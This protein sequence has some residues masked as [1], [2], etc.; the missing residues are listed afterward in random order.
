MV[1]AA[2]TRRFSAS[3]AK[4]HEVLSTFMARLA[5]T[6]EASGSFHERL[7]ECAARI[8]AAQDI[9]EVSGLLAELERATEE[10]AADSQFAQEELQDLQERVQTTD[11]QIAKLHSELDRLDVLARHDALTGALN[12]KGME[13]AVHREISKMRRAKSPLS[14]VMVDIDNFKKLNDTLGHAVGDAALRHLAVVARECLR[15]MDTVARYGGEEFLM[16]LPDTPLERGIEAIQRLQKVLAQRP[17]TNFG[18]QVDITFSAGVAQCLPT[19]TVEA[20]T[21][22][23]DEAMYQAKHGGKNRV[24]GNW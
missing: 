10:M 14:V 15:P 23:A 18:Q 12:R 2:A 6:S 20:A 8:K 24:V 9:T 5:H 4:L 17:F 13:E 1:K 3:E 7:E 16:L 19:E 21:K 22:R 11:A